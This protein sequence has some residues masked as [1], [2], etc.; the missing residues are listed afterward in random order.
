LRYIISG[1]VASLM[2]CADAAGCSD[3]GSHYT[4]LF[5]SV[6]RRVDAPVIAQVKVIEIII[7]D[8]VPPPYQGAWGR[9]SF[10]SYARVER[11]IKGAI[12][13]RIIRLI[14]PASYCA[15][16][17]GAGD[18]GI[19]IGDVRR[20]SQGELEMNAATDSYDERGMRHNR[21]KWTCEIVRHHVFWRQICRPN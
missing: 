21:K 7:G 9:H 17:L 15:Q 5:D 11:V 4:I 2:A 3:G 16:G 10:H 6:P 14:V 12:E 8:S 19:V 13:D 18:S 1:L 20:N